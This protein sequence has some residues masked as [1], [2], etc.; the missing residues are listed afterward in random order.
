MD[1]KTLNRDGLLQIDFAGVKIAIE[2]YVVEVNG[3]TDLSRAVEIVF[4]SFKSFFREELVNMLAWRA[5]KSTEESLNHILFEQ[6]E[7]LPLNTDRTI[8][9]NATMVTEPCY[10]DGFF[11][12]ALDGTFLTQSMED[13][14]LQSPMQQ[15]PLFVK[16]KERENSQIQIFLSEYTLNTALETAHNAGLIEFTAKV[17]STYLKTFFKNWEDV[18]G[19]H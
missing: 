19:K 9:L 7:I 4:N 3:N 15:L 11:T 5:A 17:T 18:M 8:H 16:D 13:T 14:K 1:L 2:D 6:G 10:N 12:V